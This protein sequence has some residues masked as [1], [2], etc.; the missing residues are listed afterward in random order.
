MSNLPPQNWLFHFLKRFCPDHLYEEIEGD[1]IQKFG[2]D[3]KVFGERKAKR[4]LLWNVIRFF[5]PGILLR[6]KFSIIL[7]LTDMFKNYLITAFRLSLRQKTYSL[8]NIL[9]LSIGLAASLLIFVYILDELSYDSYFADA[10][11]IYRVGINERFQGKEIKYTDTCVPLADAMRNEISEI[12][13]STRIGRFQNYPVRYKEKSF[14]ESRF[15]LADSNFFKFFNYKLIA[16]NDKECLKGP[17]KIII[18]EST[19]R[20]YFDYKGMGDTS[21]I[22][23]SFD[24]DNGKRT[25][26]VT[27]IIE[28]LPGNTHMKFDLLL[29]MDSWDFAVHND[30]W[31]CYSLHT[32]FK[33]KDASSIPSVEKKLSYFVDER[34]LPRI[35]KD[36]RVSIKQLHERGD[37][38]SFFVQ[39]LTSIHL[40]SHFDSEYE[41][42]GDV[43]YVYVMSIV[44]I[45]IILIACINFINLATAR[46]SSRAK[47]VGV[48]KTIGAIRIWLVQQFMIESFLYVIASTLVAFVLVV[49]MIQPLNELAGKQLGFN[50]FINPNIIV[51]ISIFLAVVGLIASIYP[52]F[53]LTSFKPAAVLKGRIQ[54]GSQRSAFRNGLVVFQFS[55]SIGLIIST[56]VIYQQLKFIQEQNLGFRKENIIKISESDGLSNQANAF[57]N[58]LLKHSEFVDASYANQLPPHVVNTLFVKS[59]DTGEM[60]ASYHIAVDYDHL[61][62][63]GYQMKSGRFFS[64]DFPSDSSAVIINETCAKMMGYENHEGKHVEFGNTKKWNVIGII[65]DFNFESLRGEIRPLVMFVSE[66]EIMMAVRMTPGSSET[67]IELAESI[68]KKFATGAPFQYSFIDEDFDSQFRAEQ[69]MG[70]LFWV[71]TTMAIFIACLGLF[72]LITFTSRL[73]VKEIG[74]RK[75]MGATVSQIV[76]LLS[77]SLLRLVL[78]AFI[79]AVPIT[80]YGMNQWLQSFAYRTNFDFV[81]VIVAGVTGM[82][83]AVLTIGYKSYKAASGN[84]VNSLKNE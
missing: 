9:G 3:V 65:K 71:F 42:N 79:I 51:S 84:P 40:E 50:L 55:I 70:K 47:E 27:A 62:T 7:N 64:K 36:L 83:I 61:K 76:L 22:G 24:L 19:A 20:K 66:R 1:L 38:V 75:V 48:R 16:G 17:N 37:K 49:I 6:N 18:T 26:E 77:G 2:H 81:L 82:L 69:R 34:I 52:S 80:W 39:P 14:I 32:Y 33:V 67:K 31:A 12:E 60:Y 45:F 57:K 59:G 46:A 28:D 13:S 29:S 44:G 72:G 4:R 21:P 23:K 10:D 11:R 35:E 58:E 78:I 53:Y 63:M 25:A 74:I 56:L 54:S 68:W 73:R 15:F 30:C 43:R 41:P 5:R 8:I